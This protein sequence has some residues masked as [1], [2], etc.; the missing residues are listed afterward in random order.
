MI[1]VAGWV[2]AAAG[3]AGVIASTIKVGGL[4][5]IHLRQRARTRLE[6]ERSA[7]SAA[8]MSGIA[9]IA[10]HPHARVRVVERDGDGER[11]IEIGGHDDFEVAA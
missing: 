11:M 9:S 2:A 3:S 10:H 1:D 5:R 7:R 8:R 6:Q 4:L